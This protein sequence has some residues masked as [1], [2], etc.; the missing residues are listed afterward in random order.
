MGSHLIVMHSA[1]RALP[2]YTRHE[3]PSIEMEGTSVARDTEHG[4][5]VTA[6][7][8]RRQA[9]LSEAIDA[10]GA[11]QQRR[12]PA[13][14]RRH[15]AG[16]AR[17]EERQV[18]RQG[19]MSPSVVRKRSPDSSSSPSMCSWAAPCSSHRSRKYAEPVSPDSSDFAIASTR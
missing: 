6:Q 16:G 7:L 9:T 2:G 4:R 1:V 19:P 13:A 14:R 15:R 17:E 11:Q 18:H 5:A 3:A 12:Q 10:A 8:A